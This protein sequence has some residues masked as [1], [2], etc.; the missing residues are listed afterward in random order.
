M[1]FFVFYQSYP[2][3]PS[4]PTPSYLFSATPPL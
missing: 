3:L 1:E 2:T 4:L